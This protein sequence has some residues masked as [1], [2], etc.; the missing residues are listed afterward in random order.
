MCFL[1][2]TST[3]PD[4][5]D[6]EHGDDAFV[7]VVEYGYTYLVGDDLSIEPIFS[8]IE[9]YVKFNM[10]AY[11]SL[12]VRTIKFDIEQHDVKSLRASLESKTTVL[13]D[14]FFNTIR[15]GLKSYL[16]EKVLVGHKSNTSILGTHTKARKS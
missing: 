8:V 6:F 14:V 16:K 11:S 12:E 7:G 4:V 15:Y 13:T 3:H 5:K 10:K 1:Y 2:D 9:N